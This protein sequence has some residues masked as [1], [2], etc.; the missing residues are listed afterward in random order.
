MNFS[1]FEGYFSNP[2]SVAKVLDNWYTR[3]FV[4]LSVHDDQC[5]DDME[6]AFKKV[7]SGTS[8]GYWM[9]EADCKFCDMEYEKGEGYA[10]VS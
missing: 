8:R 3:P 10:R 1:S 2:T 5:P 7:W 4:E 9:P 6:I